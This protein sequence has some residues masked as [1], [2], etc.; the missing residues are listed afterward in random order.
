MYL[1]E[2]CIY[3]FVSVNKKKVLVTLF[4]WKS[5]FAF[6]EVHKI[7]VYG[8]LT[9]P[10]PLDNLVSTMTLPLACLFVSDRSVYESV[11]YILKSVCTRRVQFSRQKQFF[12]TLETPKEMHFAKIEL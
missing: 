10:W 8:Y 3:L 4:N 7:S 11:K 1:V 12:C 2:V 5:R 9:F 6:I